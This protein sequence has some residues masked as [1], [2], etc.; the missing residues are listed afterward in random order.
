M[1]C[2][3]CAEWRWLSSQPATVRP[4]RLE[5]ILTVEPLRFTDKTHV[6]NI[7][8]AISKS[9]L[10]KSRTE[11]RNFGASAQSRPFRC[12][13]SVLTKFR[14]PPSL[15]KSFEAFYQ[16][17]K[18]SSQIRTLI[19]KVNFTYRETHSLRNAREV[20]QFHQSQ[21]ESHNIR[22]DSPTKPLYL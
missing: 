22:Y 5:R 8:F 7:T 14:K 4:N 16:I 11:P 3:G 18:T 6:S 20:T 2:P 21:V 9:H 1:A 19:P 13:S 12:I 10:R 15:S 17:T